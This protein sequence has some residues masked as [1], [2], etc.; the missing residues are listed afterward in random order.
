MNFSYINC[1]CIEGLVHLVRTHEGGRRSS[2]SVH[3]AYKREGAD[4]SKYV[5]R[6]VLF[7]R[8]LQY[9]HMQDTFIIASLWRQLLLLCY[10]A[11]AIIFFLFLKC[12]AVLFSM[13]L[14]IGHLKIFPLEMGG[15][16]G[17]ST[18][19]IGGHSMRTCAYNGKE[20]SYFCHFGAYVLTE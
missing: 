2:K 14:L 13:E 16:T 4:T 1:K 10:M 12:F 18:Y 7:A 3:H 5:R 8:I 15:Q 20:G 11:F 19:A 6:K 9:F 17:K